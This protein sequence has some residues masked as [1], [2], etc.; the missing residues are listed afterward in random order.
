MLKGK[1]T[2]KRVARLVHRPGRY[3]DGGGLYLEIGEGGAASWTFRWS[4][5]GRDRW[6]GLGSL[7]D[8]SLDEA[9]DLAREK[10]KL[11]RAGGDPIAERRAA[12]VERRLAQA[13][14]RTFGQCADIYFNDR[15]DN[16]DREHAA[17]W[18]ATVLGRLL[19]GRPSRSD[20]CKSLRDISVAAIDVPTVLNAVQPLWR[21]KAETARRVLGRISSVL[22]WATAAGLRGGTNPAS[23]KIVGRLLPRQERRQKSHAA[24]PVLEIPSVYAAVA[25]HPGSAARALQLCIL[26]ATRSSECLNARWSE[27]DFEDRSWTIP[28]ERMKGGVEHKIPLSDAAISLL[29]S[30]LTD[31]HDLVFLSSKPGQPLARQAMRQVLKRFGRTEAVHGFRAGLSTWASEHASA[32]PPVVEAALAHRVPDAVARAYQ[33]GTLFERRRGLMAQWAQFCVSPPAAASGN[34]VSIN[35]AVR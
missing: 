10:R 9:R 34:I 29:R 21:T 6:H 13:R 15:V 1:L 23:L 12:V 14:V 17:Q 7:R 19:D 27:I 5:G 22:D 25:A 33:R 18:S 3:G 31:G 20:H 35:T 24:V 28:R 4:D 2:I 16:W 26:C 11:V 30:L 32:P 8:V